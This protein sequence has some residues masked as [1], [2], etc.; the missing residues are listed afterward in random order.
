[1]KMGTWIHDYND[2]PLGQQIALAAK[3][4]L[5]TVR[6]YHIAYAEKFSISHLAW[7]N[8]CTN[9]IFTQKW[10]EYTVSTHVMWEILEKLRQCSSRLG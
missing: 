7:A 9:R 2:V 4:D 1:M 8:V 5:Q 3:N 10:P 6:S